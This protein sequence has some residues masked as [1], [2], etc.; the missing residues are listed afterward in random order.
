[1]KSIFIASSLG[2]LMLGCAS[3]STSR[4]K[5][6][7]VQSTSSTLFNM[8]NTP[9]V[10]TTLSGQNIKLGGF[11]GLHFIEAKEDALMFQ[12][13]TDRGPSGEGSGIDRPFLL[14][15]FSPT[16]VFLKADIATKELSVV[17]EIKLKNKDGTPL[18]GLPNTRL[19]EN[20]T[21]IF[22]LYYS[23]DQQGLD[24][25]GLTPDGEGGW[26]MSDEYAPSLVHFNDE[27]KMLRRLTPSNELPRMYSERK[28]N[29]GFEGI[30]K[31]E[32]KLYGILQ[33][34]LPKERPAKD[35]EFSLIVEVDL[36]TMKTSAEYF[37]MFEKGN[38]K[39]GDMVALNSK[40]F[41]VIEQNGKA[42]EHSQKYIYRIT[43]GESDQLVKKT[44]IA[45]LKNTPFNNVEKVEG[46][47]LVDNKRLAIVYDN[48]FQINGKTNQATGLTPL[49]ESVNQLLIL[50]FSESLFGQAAL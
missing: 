9:F 2:L 10:G 13:V 27:G 39:I 19:E 11:S 8:T 42:G 24:I 25:E 3:T 38:D 43:L 46:L 32:N 7:K 26:W 47:A 41:L 17:A 30:S 31:I 40:N 12:T 36:E 33:S 35:G 4:P 37:Y 21:D 18:T 16:I 20:P 45:D 34:P 5:L 44:L 48:D 28:T 23:V 6:E 1:M 15:E 29:R 14:P 22:G 50:E 49:N